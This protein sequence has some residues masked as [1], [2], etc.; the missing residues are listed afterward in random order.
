[1]GGALKEKKKNQNGFVR[2]HRLYRLLRFEVVDL[3]F[4][5]VSLISS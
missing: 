1:M 2:Y 5:N 4:A 3:I